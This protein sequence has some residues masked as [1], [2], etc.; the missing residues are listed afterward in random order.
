MRWTGSS[1][2]FIEKWKRA[3]AH[4]FFHSGGTVYYL[5]GPEA[6]ARIGTPLARGEFALTS[7]TIDEFL[8]AVRSQ[9]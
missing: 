8:K 5:A 6:A 4:V 1:K 9:D 3:T 2:Q 7:L